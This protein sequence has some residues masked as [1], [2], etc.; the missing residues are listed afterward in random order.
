MKQA[1][2][3]LK[4]STISEAIGVAIICVALLVA[5]SSPWLI[6]RDHL[7]NTPPAEYT[8]TYK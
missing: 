5:L 6:S 7:S 3:L 1:E 8:V 2:A 4:Q